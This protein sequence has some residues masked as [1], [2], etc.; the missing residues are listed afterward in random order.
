MGRP[1][2]GSCGS[3]ALEVRLEIDRLRP[4]EEGWG[5][6]S[7]KT[8]LELTPHLRS[9]DIPSVRAINRYLKSKGR[10]RSYRMNEVLPTEPCFPCKHPHDVWQMDAE[11]NKQV[12][13]VGTVCM[14][15]IKDTF[16][17]IY[18]GAYPCV[19]AGKSNHPKKEHYQ[20]V[21]RLGFVEFGMCK[22]LQVDH[23]SIY[24]ENTTTTPFPTPFHLWAIGLDLPL[25]FTPGGKPFK[26]GAV[27][28]EH[29]TMHR[30]VCAGRAYANSDELFAACQ[31]RR[32][33]LNYHIPCR[34][35]N[36]KAPLVVFPQALRSPRTY[37]PRKE[38]ECFD[39]ARIYEFLSHCRWLRRLTNQKTFSLGAQ[40]YRLATAKPNTDLAVTFNLETKCFRCCDADGKL[41]AEIQPKGISFKELCGNLDEF[42]H[43]ATRNP[44]VNYP[45]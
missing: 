16:T 36:G 26:Q 25:C 20:W 11:G 24:Y 1:R 28:R 38:E 42:I 22:R 18:A 9:V 27:E 19:F 7:I 33:R 29:Q 12:A 37:D 30:Q 5:A 31:Q 35:L 23:E 41:I 14:I 45:A 32:Q 15:N 13:G 43:W 4:G 17:K 8:E 34:M 21:L 3:F 39:L 40:S 2:C 44:N 10:S 6:A